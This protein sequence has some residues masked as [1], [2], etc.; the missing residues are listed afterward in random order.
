MGHSVPY[1]IATDRASS[2]YRIIVLKDGQIAEQGTFKELLEADSV[3]ATMWA[4]HTQQAPATG[5]ASSAIGY[6]VEVADAEA[7]SGSGVI[8]ESPRVATASLPPAASVRSPS[9][10][11]PAASIRAESTAPTAK[12]NNDP[13]A[14]PTSDAEVEPTPSPA[15]VAFP[16]SDN[17]SAQAPAPVSFPTSDDTHSVSSQPRPAIPGHVHGASVTFDTTTTPPRASTPDP[18]GTPKSEP[19][20]GKRKRISSQN[21]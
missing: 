5:S 19:A 15:P 6:D 14:F 17:T 7:V 2:N 10:R 16:T 9:V 13:V 20:D 12:D 1:K 11:A 3:F 8:A 18:T 21:F 4:E